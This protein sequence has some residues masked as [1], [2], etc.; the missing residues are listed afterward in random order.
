ME[1]VEWIEVSPIKI[2]T[3]EKEYLSKNCKFVIT[4][5][6]N[7]EDRV[8]TF[9]GFFSR[10]IDDKN[11]S[12]EVQPSTAFETLEECQLLAERLILAEEKFNESR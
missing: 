12:Y 3:F 1:K 6:Y 10:I 5:H 4:S 9:K 8:F 2:T 11:L 7:N